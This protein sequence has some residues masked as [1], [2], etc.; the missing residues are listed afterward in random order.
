MKP[1]KNKSNNDSHR[2]RKELAKPH[3]TKRPKP[4]KKGRTRDITK[5]PINPSIIN[6]DIFP[7]KIIAG[8][9]ERKGDKSILSVNQSDVSICF[10]QK[11]EL[12][13]IFQTL[14]DD[15]QKQAFQHFQDLVNQTNVDK[16]FYDY[17]ILSTEKYKKIYL[18]RHPK[19]T[20]DNKLKQWEVDYADYLE[21][22]ALITYPLDEQYFEG[23]LKQA[24]KL[25]HQVCS[26]IYTSM[27]QFRYAWEVLTKFVSY[28][29]TFYMQ[30]EY[31]YPLPSEPVLVKENPLSIDENWVKNGKLFNEITK[32][33][34]ADWAAASK[35]QN[36]SL[37][38]LVFSLIAFGGINDKELLAALVNTLLD[39]PVLTA[40]NDHHV[41]V[42]VRYPT[43]N[44][45]NERVESPNVKKSSL[46]ITQQV[47]LDVIS[48]CWLYRCRK[49]NDIFKVRTSTDIERLLRNHL[50]EVLQVSKNKVPSLPWWLSHASYHWE[51]MPNVFVDQAL[52][53]VAQGKRK[54]T[55]LL[56]D[57]FSTLIN[58]EYKT[59]KPSLS[60]EAP[61]SKVSK[62][63]VRYAELA[64]VRKIDIVKRI[65]KELDNHYSTRQQKER[66]KDNEYDINYSLTNML[67]E[68]RDIAENILIKFVLSRSNAT[69][70]P[71][72]ETIQGY[73][74]SVAYEWLYFLS[75]QPLN[76]YSSE[77]FEECYEEILEHKA[78]YRN[79]KDIQY[80]AKLLQR[81]HDIGVKYYHFPKVSI[82]EAQTQ[83]VVRS[84]WISPL[85]YQA[86]LLNI[87]KLV[88]PLEVDMYKLL[89]VLAYRTGMR[90]KELLG[91]RYADI[92][93]FTLGE[94]SLVIR[95]NIYRSTKTQGSIRRVA[96]FS[97]LSDEE[98]NF[99][100]RYVQLN[101]LNKTDYIFSPSYDKYPIDDAEPLAVL[102]KIL[103]LLEAK[104]HTFHAFRHTAITNLSLILNAD[105]QLVKTLT[106]YSDQ[107]IAKIKIGL[108]GVNHDA[109]DKWY[110]ISGIAG[111]VSPNRSFEY[112]IH[113]AM[114]MT[115][116][117]IAN[118]EMQ[119]DYV[120]FKN[121]TDISKDRLK[122]NSIPIINNK[123][124]ISDTRKLTKKL[125]LN[126][127]R[128]IPVNLAIDIA[129]RFKES[130]VFTTNMADDRVHRYGINQL[131]KF[132]QLLE[133]SG[134]IKLSSNHSFIKLE[135]G[136]IFAK[137][138]EQIAHITTSQGK[139]RFIETTDQR[140]P[141]SIK[142]RESYELLPFILKS[143]WSLR[144]QQHADYLWF[145]QIVRQKITINNA[146]LSFPVKDI[147]EFLRFAQ[148][149]VRLLPAQSWMIAGN[150]H[151]KA[152]L[153][154]IYRTTD[155]KPET[156][157]IIFKPYNSSTIRFGICITNEQA[158][159]GKE[160]SGL[161]KFLVHLF[162]IVDDEV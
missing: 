41:I 124:S 91:L 62:N 88:D 3:Q 143:V 118:T 16:K 108:L 26:K 155:K 20:D 157:K 134:D 125:T 45:G 5:Q 4:K 43:K 133:E 44:Y 52:I 10:Y 51:M 123:I 160:F 11:Y 153:N 139:C 97:L 100:N 141:K 99:F 115:T 129:D 98:L 25:I 130:D 75:G 78:V 120:I 58:K 132:L 47:S 159:N 12:L 105:D 117:A 73:L 104:D 63:T 19:P 1:L 140:Q 18:E 71:K 147:E 90:K 40:F 146:Y 94:P 38:S 80:S 113:S 83:R 122:S 112:Y 24:K 126:Q 46:Y 35:D 109:Q 114:L 53:G 30:S 154:D 9:T 68:E 93:G 66:I 17:K 92:E 15:I 28:Y 33:V 144:D 137:R 61:L 145:L 161:L 49:F 37:A 127:S 85:A 150:K 95:P 158:S 29:N 23:F 13:N 39:Q 87:P 8:F 14:W 64:E 67:N 84:E 89:F 142:S 136:Q 82:K 77:D 74:S 138:A 156:S 151:V 152:A 111:H 48:Q 21:Q 59:N 107:H 149:S 121:I 27:A 86:I 57:D 162:M 72:K 103:S 96:A 34:M 42:S 56:T 81:L 31:H 55:G 65:Y 101:K 106:G 50:S 22:L 102:R 2:S 32:A 54:T 79:N 128:D 119:L 70:R 76:T 60:V 7:P 131:I 116:Y 69:P 6:K 36:Q 135:D 148:I 110:A